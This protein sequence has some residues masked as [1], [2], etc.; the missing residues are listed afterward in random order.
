M[1]TS[2]LDS[3]LFGTHS[4]KQSVMLACPA[5][6]LLLVIV[7][8]EATQS[9]GWLMRS[10]FWVSHIAVG[11]C[12][13]L[14]IAG[15][16]RA[17]SRFGTVERKY[18]LPVIA[19]TGALGAVIAAPF[20]TLLDYWFPR[21]LDQW[22][23][24]DTSGLFPAIAQTLYRSGPTFIAIWICVNLPMLFQRPVMVGLPLNNDKGAEKEPQIKKSATIKTSEGI[25]SNKQAEFFASLPKVLG[26]ELVAVSS[27]LHYINVYTTTGK[28]LVLG[29]LKHVAEMFGEEGIMVHRSHWLHKQQ[30]TRVVINSQ[31][32]YCV[33]ISGLQI[34]I[35]RSRRKAVAAEFGRGAINTG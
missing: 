22:A 8:P 34:P 16:V 4:L 26:R 3:P 14:A 2:S 35:S 30:V 11:A 5:I 7:Q 27:Y 23:L 32:A 19:A 12:I 9:Y 10:A 33:M 21:D 25:N 6:S 24:A 20:F 29:S 13:A 18:Y 15:V 1:L 31:A 28:A 17:I